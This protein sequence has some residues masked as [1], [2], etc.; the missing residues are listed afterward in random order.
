MSFPS[1]TAARPG[2]PLIL[3]T[4]VA[5]CFVG[6]GAYGVMT[7]AA[8]LPYF[9]VAGIGETAARQLMPWIGAMDITLGFL[10]LVWPCRALL[11]W[12][13]GWCVWTA[14]LRPLAGQGWPEFFERAGNYGV[15]IALLVAAGLRGSLFT[16]LPEQWELTADGRH[17]LE[18]VLRLTTCLLLAGHAACALVLHKAAL[19]HHY[20]VFGPADPAAVMRAVGWF[21]LLLAGAV[22]AGPFAALAV[23]VCVWKVATESLMLTSGAPAPFFDFIEHG[24]SYAAPLALAWLLSRPG[25]AFFPQPPSP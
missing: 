1:D 7:K 24:G 2:L 9:N 8:W 13:A 23:F 5:L 18:W 4:G 15:P 3:R 12:G 25:A 19:A 16:R 20:A 21:E 22:L 14:L 6:H 17:R 11:L 10:A